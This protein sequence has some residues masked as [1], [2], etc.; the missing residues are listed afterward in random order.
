MR[1]NMLNSAYDWI[2]VVKLLG[3]ALIDIRG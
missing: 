3:I 1:L 2:Y